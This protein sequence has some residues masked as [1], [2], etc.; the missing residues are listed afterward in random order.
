[1]IV[2]GEKGRCLQCNKLHIDKSETQSWCMYKNMRQIV[3]I[4]IEFTNPKMKS[5]ELREKYKGQLRLKL[6]NKINPSWCPY[7]KVI[8]GVDLADGSDMVN[9]ISSWAKEEM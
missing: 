6:E 9:V 1:M 7:R 3:S 8:I 5:L 2:K 4:D